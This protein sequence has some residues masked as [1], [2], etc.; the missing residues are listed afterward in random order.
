MNSLNETLIRD[1]VTEVLGK[2]GGTSTA[3]NKPAAQAPAPAPAAKAG[4]CGCSAKKVSAANVALRGKF[5]VFQDAN[6]ACAAAQ[7]AYL[8]LQKRHG[9]AAQN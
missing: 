2:L 9:G 5:G 6:E 7:E 8:L 1:V 3:T 4:D